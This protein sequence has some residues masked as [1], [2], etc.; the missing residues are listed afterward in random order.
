M[1]FRSVASPAILERSGV[2][3]GARLA[4]LGVAPVAD[5]PGV[6]ENLQD[7]LQLRTIFRVEGTRTLN[8]DYP[9]LLKRAWMGLEYALFRKG[10]MSMAPSTFGAF[11]RSSPDVAT[12]NL[13]FH[14]Q[15]LSLDRFGEPMHPF[16]AFTVSVCNLRP[17]SRGSIHARSADPAAAPVIAPNY[18]PTE[19]DRRIAADSI[20]LA[21]RVVAA[22]AL[23][24]FR[25]QEFKPGPGFQTQAELEKAAGDVGT[26][27]FHPVGTARMGTADDPTAVVDVRLRVRGVEGL[28]VVDASVMPTIVSGNTNSPTIMIADKGAGMILADRR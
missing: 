26:T 1:L 9:N 6:G 24:K 17:A 12:P 7:H 3:A 20:R 15:P 8:T 22:P 23:A 25:P 2:G 27:I 13:E 21:R 16:A 18:L 28:R 14:V 5:V 19:E 11:T 10:P 4:A